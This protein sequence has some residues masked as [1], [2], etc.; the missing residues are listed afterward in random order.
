MIDSDLYAEREE[1]QEDE[2]Q[3]LLAI[4]DKYDTIKEMIEDGAL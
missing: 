2:R 1:Q 3:V 4:A